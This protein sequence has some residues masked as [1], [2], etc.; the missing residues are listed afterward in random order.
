MAANVSLFRD[1]TA[2]NYDE[3]HYSSSFLA[4]RTDLVR[5]YILSITSII[6]HPLPRIAMHYV[7]TSSYFS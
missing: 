5:Y 6:G 7:G 2:V 1:N 3:L 4:I